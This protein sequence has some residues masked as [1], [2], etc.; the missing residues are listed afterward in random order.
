MEV[1]LM[2]SAVVCKTK[3]HVVYSEQLINR[4]HIIWIWLSVLV[5]QSIVYV[6][7]WLDMI[8]P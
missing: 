5:G 2:Y 1:I 8:I 3:E 6:T 7:N 4:L